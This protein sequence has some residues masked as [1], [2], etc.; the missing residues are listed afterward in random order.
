MNGCKYSCFL[1]LLTIVATNALEK[2]AAHAEARRL[3]P[4]IVFVMV[5]DWGFSDVGFRN[6]DI[7][8]PNFD[9]LARTGLLLNRHYAFRYCSP[10]RA[11]FLTGRWPHHAHQ[12]NIHQGQLFGANLDFTM[13]PAKLKR[14]GYAT[15]LVGKWHEG[16]YDRRY[17]P[18]HR[19]FDS[20]SGILNA[21]ADYFTQKVG[22]GGEVT[23]FWKNE[24]PDT[25]NGSYGSYT[26]LADAMELLTQHDL[27]VPLFLYLSLQ[28]VHAPA[29]AP[30]EWLDVYET[31]SVCWKRRKHQA[32]VSVAD[33]ITGEVVELLKK[34]RMWENTLFV[35]SSDNGGSACIG[36]NHPLRGS[37]F[38]FFEG[39]VR[40]LA[41]V[42]GGL[43]PEKMKGEVTDVMTHLA[44]WYPTFCNLAGVDPSDSGPGKYPV[45]GVDLWPY[46]TGEDTTN[47][48][49]EI[50]LGVN[51][52]RG[53][54]EQ[55]A[56][57]AGKYKLIVGR[58]DDGCASLMW[59][60]KNYPCQNG[61]VGPDCDPYCL[62]N[63]IDDP[64]ET[65][66]ISG[67]EPE[68]LEQMLNRYTELCQEPQEYYTTASVPRDPNVCD[69]MIE[70]GSYW[71]PW[72]N[73]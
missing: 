62:Y 65:K 7:K 14:A 2:D 36:S 8:S 45:D 30:K 26:F 21:H 23:D 11:S 15:H 57:I 56:L 24:A 18:V 12:D 29:E 66:D 10:S 68:I 32:M 6:P 43:L 39:G 72:K 61:I 17:L 35:V 59:A 47:P 52:T 42:N 28:N 53:H 33:N 64:S 4:H 48:H 70:H 46:I 20:S 37:K 63:I 44:D 41:F 71:R 22:C 1:L 40:V 58:Q 50:V 60:P 34:R 51:F 9:E 69:Y 5:D 38:T 31:S 67:D 25:R 19:G 3:K 13:I 16:F 73:L 54:P 55:G 27:S 49:D